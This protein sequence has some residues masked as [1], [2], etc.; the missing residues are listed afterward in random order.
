MQVQRLFAD[1]LRRASRKKD[2]ASR[3]GGEEFAL[4]LA[5]CDVDEALALA[6]RIRGCFQEDARYVDGKTFNATVSVGVAAC[7]EHGD[8]FEDLLEHADQAL[9]RAKTL[10]RNRRRLK[11]AAPTSRCRGLRSRAVVQGAAPTKSFAAY[12]VG[13]APG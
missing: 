1:A 8:S 11:S 13:A 6:R 10:R 7:P 9:Y 5:R 4:V 2:M 12:R 3:I